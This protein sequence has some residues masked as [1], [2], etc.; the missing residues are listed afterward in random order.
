MKRFRA[1]SI[2]ALL[3]PIAL[4]GCASD[5]TPPNL[6]CPQVA[7]LQQTQSLTSFLPGRSDVAAQI[8]TAQVTGVAGA[9]ILRPEK[10]AL[11]VKFQAGFSATNGPANNGAPLNLPFFVAIT[12]GDQIL[13]KTDYTVALKFNGNMS[14]AQTTSKPITVELPDHHSSTRIQILV[15]FEL[16]PDQLSYA[17][18]HPVGGP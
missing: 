15:G 2:F 6:P 7:V 16:T 10:H 3:S 14:T 8:T 9:C 1:A 12:Q 18:T 4:A 13:S 17:A 5:S 11:D